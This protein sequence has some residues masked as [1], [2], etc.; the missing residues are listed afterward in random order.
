M[1]CPTRP[2]PEKASELNAVSAND[3]TNSTRNKSYKNPFG[4][5]TL[6]SDFLDASGFCGGIIRAFWSIGQLV[7]WSIQKA[8]QGKT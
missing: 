5:E 8:K 6:G 2:N 3:V 7:N 1:G 4:R